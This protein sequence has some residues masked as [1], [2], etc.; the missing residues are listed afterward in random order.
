MYIDAKAKSN[1]GENHIVL[2][3]LTQWDQSF[4][5]IDCPVPQKLHSKMI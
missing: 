5:F 3:E 1:L 2:L 4:R